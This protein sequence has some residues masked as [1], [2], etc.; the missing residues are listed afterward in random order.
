MDVESPL[1]IP[2]FIPHRGCPHQC[3]FCNQTAITGETFASSRSEAITG[4]AFA[5]SRSEAITGEAFASSRS[6]TITGEAFDATGPGSINRQ[7]SKFLRH[8]RQHGK[9]VQIAFY[10]G[11]FLGLKQSTVQMLLDEAVHFV[12]KGVVD[13]IRFSTRPDTIDAE[14]LD[15]IRDFPVS[16]VELGVQSMNDRVLADSSR[17]HSARDTERAVKLLKERDYDI[18]LQMMV[19]L[20]GDSG[21][22]CLM[23]AERIASLSPD[24]VRIYPTLVIAGSPLADQ[25]KNG[26]YTP[27]TLEKCVPLVVAVYRIFR[28]NAIKVARMG[29]QE[30]EDLSDGAV[31]LA[32]PHH[33][34]FGHLVYSRLFL[35]MA[36]ARLK[37]VRR[38]GQSVAIRVHPRNV[39]R[40]RG[41]KN[42][43]VRA[44]KQAFEIKRLDV[45][46]DNAVG[47]ETLTIETASR[48][49]F[50]RPHE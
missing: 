46:P 43:N 35:D 3:A 41:M 11:N 26:A 19:G 10:G 29:L 39:S 16:T 7:I 21:N 42:D 14:R 30:S 50:L 44:L 17:G 22:E 1:I 9:H 24:F 36:T 23:T 40:M 32:G 37:K 45:L 8:K 15:Y 4:A 20:P 48:A 34:A 31:V 47:E 49:D 13:S 25:Y 28:R 5:T 12:K 18:G 33:P 6:E 27:L 2:V 38:V